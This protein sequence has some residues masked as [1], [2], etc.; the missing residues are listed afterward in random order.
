MNQLVPIAAHAPALVRTAGERAQT[1]FW[2]FFV[3]NIRNPHTR[4]AYGRSIVEFLAWCKQ[5]GLASII[6]PLHVGTYI[7]AVTRSRSAPTAKQK[8]A[9]IRMLFDW[10]VTGQIVPTNPAASVRGPKHIVKVGKTAVLD[11]TEARV[12][13]DSIDVTTRAGLRDRALISLMVYSFA[14]VGAALAMKV[15]D[16]YV[17]NRRLWV[18]LH[19]KGGKRHETPCHHN[20]E[21]YLHAY[22]DGCGLASDP[23]G[24]LFRTIGRDTGELTSTPLPQPNAY[25]MIRRRAIDAGIATKVGNHSF[26]A[27]GITA[28]L[29]NSTQLE[30]AD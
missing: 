17:Q 14:R 22:I 5:H 25:A 2:E 27:T 7:E 23:K 4:R 16:V 30:K 15:E 24:L 3:S 26:R 8:L 13:L 18:R 10:L 9:A 11:V 1:R 12:L 29:K 19:E 20:L 21:A 6:E 28:Y